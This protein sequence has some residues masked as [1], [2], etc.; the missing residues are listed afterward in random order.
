MHMAEGLL[1]LVWLS[2]AVLNL[3]TSQGR[4][5]LSLTPPRGKRRYV[6][7]GKFDAKSLNSPPQRVREFTDEQLSVSAG[8]HFCQTYRIEGIKLSTLKSHIKM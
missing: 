7:R 1:F 3:R 8:K 6:G 4:G 5:K 2:Y